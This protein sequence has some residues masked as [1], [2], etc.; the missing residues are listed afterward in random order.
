[1]GT[2]TERQ[3][4][5]N[6]TTGRRAIKA[7][8]AVLALTMSLGLAACG[9]DDSSTAAEPAASETTSMAPSDDMSSSDA[10]SD[11]GMDPASQVFGPACDQVPADG[12]GSFQG[13][14]TAPVASAAS[15]NPLLKTLVAAVGKAGLVDTL[16]SADGITVFAPVDDAFA[17]IPKKDLN[18]VLKDKK[19]LTTILTHHVIAGQLSPDQLAG[20]HDTLAGDTLTVA[21]SGEDFMVGAENAT[22][23]C[24]NV[25]TANATVY[26]IDTVLMPKM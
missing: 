22:I 5:N 26:I 14:A 1:M 21:G 13:M 15:A 25:P 11:S 23:L 16:N 20:D 3:N 24:G 17:K 9:A 12:D 18:A 4:M 8:L 10:A 6:T 7:G 2:S 19:T